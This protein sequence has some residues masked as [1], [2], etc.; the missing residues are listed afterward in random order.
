MLVK[1][2]VLTAEWLQNFLEFN[3]NKPETLPTWKI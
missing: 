1:P 3:D 2:D